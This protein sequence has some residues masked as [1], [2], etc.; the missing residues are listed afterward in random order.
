LGDG[1]AESRGDAPFK[2]FYS[3]LRQ[4]LPDL[5]VTVDDLLAEGD[6]VAA[7]VTLE[8]THTSAVLGPPASGRKVRFGAILIARIAG[9]KI[10]QAW[11]NV[12][13]LTLLK[14]IGALPPG[15]I[16]E[17]FLTTRP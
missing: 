10:A 2:V 13:P 8:G 1:A 9:G 4:A 17:N 7:R 11:N 15:T 14:Q 3:N 6:K 12:D 16:R 5:H